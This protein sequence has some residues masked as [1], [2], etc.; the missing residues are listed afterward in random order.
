MAVLSCTI[1]DDVSGSD[2]GNKKGYK[3]DFIIQAEDGDQPATIMISNHPDIPKVGD[4]HPIDTQTTVKSRAVTPTKNRAY[5][6]LTVN[7]EY[8]LNA[9]EDGG[10]GGGGG[11]ALQV[12]DIQGGVWYEDYNIE[13]DFSEEAKLYK[14]SAGDKIEKI[15]TRSHPMFTVVTRSQEFLVPDYIYNTNHVNNNS[16]SILGLNFL[17]NTVL[18]DEFNFKSIDNGYWEYTFSFKVKLAPKPVISTGNR[19][20]GRNQSLG[21]KDAILDAGYREKGKDEELIPI[22]PRKEEGAQKKSAPVSSPWPLDGSGKSLTIKEVEESDR[23]FWHFF[24]GKPRIGFWIFNFDWTTLL[25]DH[26][27]EL[28]F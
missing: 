24:Q 17:E 21:W 11:S 16:W 27:R 4:P 13:Q 26:A 14:N 7:Y 23:I 12:L 8:A 18:F 3:E 10:G 28:G 22:I 6:I 20:E 9:G 1:R 5:F 15:A 25:T 19:E 2:D